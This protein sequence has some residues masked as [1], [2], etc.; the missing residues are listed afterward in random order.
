M[1]TVSPEKSKTDSAG[2]TEEAKVDE[3]DRSSTNENSM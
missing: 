2:E 3:I 1:K